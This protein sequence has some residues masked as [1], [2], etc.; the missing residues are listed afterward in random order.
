MVKISVKIS[1]VYQL[2]VI[3]KKINTNVREKVFL[4]FGL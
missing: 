4:N 1:E 3:S 2:I